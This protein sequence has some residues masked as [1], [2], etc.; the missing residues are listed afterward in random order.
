MGDW[1]LLEH[2]RFTIGDFYLDV[3]TD[4]V[5]FTIIIEPFIGLL[6][7]RMNCLL[8]NVKLNKCESEKAT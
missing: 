2:D 1:L 5:P 3:Q 8:S 7:L 4:A 6:G